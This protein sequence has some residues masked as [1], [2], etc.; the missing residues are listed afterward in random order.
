MLNNL[1]FKNKNSNN[2]REEIG[3]LDKHIIK[4]E[5]YLISSLSNII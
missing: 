2:S 5:Y 4:N 1:K 3:D